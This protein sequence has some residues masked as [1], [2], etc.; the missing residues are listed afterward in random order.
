MKISIIIPVYNECDTILNVIERV[1][2]VDMLVEKEL[3]IVD[4]GSSD[5]TTEIIK[6]NESIVNKAVYHDKNKGKGAAIQTGLKNASGDYVVIQD[7]DLEYDPQDINKLL[8]PILDGRADVVYGSRFAGGDIH[9]VLY[10]WHSVGNKLLTLL[11][12]MFANLNLTDMETCYK[13]FRKEVLAGIDIKEK[14][15]GFEPEITLKVAKRR[16]RFFEVSISYSGRT[17]REGKKINWKD[18]FRAI[19]CIFKYSIFYKDT[20]SELK[21]D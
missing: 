14:R 1:K 11:L 6:Q 21:T 3:I 8:I 7:A 13:M 4:D 20:L 18:G 15:F 17:Y 16:V 19:W 5:G 10:F 2:K 9:R 12:N